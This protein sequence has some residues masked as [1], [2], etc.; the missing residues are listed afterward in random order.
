MA[1]ILAYTSPSLGNLFPLCALLDELHGRGHRVVV[2]TL[3]RGLPTVRALGLEAEPI[4]PRI[5]A[6]EMTDWEASGGRAAL[7][8]ALGVF[9]KRA[10]VEVD[11]MRRAIETTAPDAIIVDANCWGASAV[12]EATGLP[13]SAFWPFFPFLRS[14]GHPPYGPGLRP[15][16][17]WPGRVRDGLLNP[18][19]TAAVANPMLPRVNDI[20]RALGLS[21]VGS[22]EEFL[23]RPPLILLASASPLDYPRPDD[24][25]VQLIGPCEFEPRSDADLRWLEDIDAPLVLVT[26]SSE[27]QDDAALG[28]AAITALAD[29]PVHVVATFPCGVPD[30]LVLPRNATA[31]EFVPHSPVLARAVCA[32]THGGMG[33]TQKA[34]A[35]G[36]P[37]CVVPHGRDQFEVARRVE[38]A[39]CG[40]R[41]PAKRLTASRLRDAVVRAMSMTDGARRVAEGFVASGG[42]G[43]GADLV[44]GGLA[45]A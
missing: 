39:R 5:E 14:P 13:W 12:A 17:G 35:R 26:M 44:E 29:E 25:P 3:A 37:V 27:R 21:E 45:G 2:R 10:V 34:L 36:V 20:R 4:D 43:R 16:R 7:K 41:L 18:V 28:L 24:G 33:A 32:V 15:W 30:S 31:V 8:V 22:T 38:V 40:T 19:V 9:G 11:D 23:R 6:I 1:T 42:V